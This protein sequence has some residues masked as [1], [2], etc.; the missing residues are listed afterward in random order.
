MLAP[1]EGIGPAVGAT[2]SID[3]D[4]DPMQRLDQHLAALP[5]LV[6]IGTVTDEIPISTEFTTTTTGA[7]V[8]RTPVLT[9]YQ[10]DNGEFQSTVHIEAV[11]KGDPP[12]S[13]LVMPDL[14]N[15]WYCVGG[16][17]LHKGD[18]LLLLLDQEPTWTSNGEPRD[19]I[20]ETGPS[21]GNIVLTPDRAVLDD[22]LPGNSS[23]LGPSEDVVRH[24]AAT[25]GASEAQTQSALDTLRPSPS[26]DSHAK[27]IVVVITSAF[28]VLIIATGVVW[29]RVQR[30]R[31]A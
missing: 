5:E 21:G 15:N 2:C 10:E 31:D 23:D 3:P 8:V 30:R 16:P 19:L 7:T 4:P 22:H 14:S 11:L 17:R 28:A 13:D 27:T 29:W 18:R 12:A 20:W 1:L 24:V 9:P 25:V 6:V 26:D